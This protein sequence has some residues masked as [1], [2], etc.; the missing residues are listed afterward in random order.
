MDPP[1]VGLMEMTMADRLVEWK[2][3][4]WVEMKKVVMMAARMVD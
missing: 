1:T 3:V 2:V 4:Q